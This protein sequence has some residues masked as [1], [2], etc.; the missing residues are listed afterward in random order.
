LIGN[1]WFVHKP[2]H[3]LWFDPKTKPKQKKH[4]KLAENTKTKKN[5]N[6][7]DQTPQKN[8]EHQEH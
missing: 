5:L 7:T 1:L 6:K 4:I 2:N 8:E 3:K